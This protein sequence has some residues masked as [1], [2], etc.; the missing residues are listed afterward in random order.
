MRGERNCSP[1]VSWEVAHQIQ[2][3]SVFSGSVHTL[4][5]LFHTQLVWH[6][7]IWLRILSS[8]IYSLIF[9]PLQEVP[10]K[11]EYGGVYAQQGVQILMLVS[12]TVVMGMLFHHTCVDQHYVC[13]V[14]L[15]DIHPK[16]LVAIHPG[17]HIFMGPV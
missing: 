6:L 13:L 11:F 12:S 17:C 16:Y 8:A 14:N 3:K 15:L 5:I 9:S 1:T 4:C 2:H 10:L 7:Q